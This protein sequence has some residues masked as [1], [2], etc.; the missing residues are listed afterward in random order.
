V[1]LAKYRFDPLGQFGRQRRLAGEQVEKR[2]RRH[3]QE[4]SR[5]A[6]R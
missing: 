3:P 5:L 6:N 4:M 1:Y 2:A